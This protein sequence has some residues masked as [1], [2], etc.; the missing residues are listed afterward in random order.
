MK[1]LFLLL[2][3]VCLAVSCTENNSRGKISNS[4]EEEV[5]YTLVEYMMLCGYTY[6][7]EV[8]AYRYG[9]DGKEYYNGTE[10][11]GPR[12]SIRKEGFAL[13][14][15][16]YGAVVVPRHYLQHTDTYEYFSKIRLVK[17]TVGNYTILTGDTYYDEYNREKLEKNYE[18]YNATFTHEG[19]VYYFKI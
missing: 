7:G 8:I 14:E 15:T 12:T 17:V 18:R 4:N 9:E 19:R 10:Y 3:V 1:K 5:K 6:S 2:S 11:Y 16:E 13:F